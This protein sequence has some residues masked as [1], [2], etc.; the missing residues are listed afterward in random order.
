MTTV[1]R[2]FHIEVGEAE[3]EVTAEF[4]THDGEAFELRGIEAV[5]IDG[6]WLAAA[7]VFGDAELAEA[8][9]TV[10]KSMG[11]DDYDALCREAR[12]IEAGIE[13][14]RDLKDRRNRGW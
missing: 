3:F 9:D 11:D 12:E 2:E 8:N 7:D 5:R 1:V 14:D 4:D 10:E 6:Q 13:C